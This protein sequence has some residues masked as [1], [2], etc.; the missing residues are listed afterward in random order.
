MHCIP[1]DKWMIW[2]LVNWITRASHDQAF[3]VRQNRFV[4]APHTNWTPLQAPETR[5]LNAPN[6]LPARHTLTIHGLESLAVQSIASIDWRAR[7]NLFV[8][9]AQ[10]RMRKTL[11]IENESFDYLDCL[12]EFECDLWPV[13]L[14]QQFVRKDCNFSPSDFLFSDWNQVWD[15]PL[16]KAPL[17]GEVWR[18][19]FL[20]KKEKKSESILISFSSKDHS[21]RPVT[22]AA[23]FLDPVTSPVWPNHLVETFWFTWTRN[24][25][26]PIFGH[27]HR[28]DCVYCVWWAVFGFRRVGSRV[29][30]IIRSSLRRSNNRSLGAKWF[31]YLSGD[32]TANSHRT[33]RENDLRKIQMA[34]DGKKEQRI[35][36]TYGNPKSQTLLPYK[37]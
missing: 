31:N 1:L 20:S 24:G 22:R 7:F 2:K 9:S 18:K 5:R 30:D 17:D 10:D 19:S 29:S 32:Q 26:I 6:L 33:S 11:I 36:W 16:S 8:K 27:R 23:E 3:S 35:L 15:D 25:Y 4:I 12:V 21:S 28:L 37:L 13:E 14:W 34:N